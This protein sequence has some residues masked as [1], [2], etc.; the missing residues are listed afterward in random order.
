MV[1][2]SSDL[3]LVDKMVDTPRIHSFR[4]ISRAAGGYMVIFA[5]RLGF[6]VVDAFSTVSRK[7]VQGPLTI[8]GVHS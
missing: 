1:A 6:L 5:S 8:T 7:L 2:V 4:E 3:R